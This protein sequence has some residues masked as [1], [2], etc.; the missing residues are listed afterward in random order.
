MAY[1]KEPLVVNGTVIDL[2][3]LEP[4][5]FAIIPTDFTHS[6]NIH[7]KFHNHCFSES[8]TA[9]TEQTVLQPPHGDSHQPRCFSQDR[10]ELSKHLA[11]LIKGFE[12]KTVTRSSDGNLVRIELPEGR[13]YAIFFTLRKTPDRQCEMTVISAFCPENPKVIADSGSMKFKLAVC[14]ILRNQPLKMPR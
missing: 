3:H 13:N 8:I 1:W 10:Y 11:A 7:V 12:R 4:F 14:K 6:V 2:A 9:D 5:T